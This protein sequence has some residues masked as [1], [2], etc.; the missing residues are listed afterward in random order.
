MSKGVASRTSRERG[1]RRGVSRFTSSER[2]GRVLGELVLGLALV[3]GGAVAMSAWFQRATTPTDVVVLGRDLQ[4]GHI[5]TSQDL[6]TAVVRGA[7]GLRVMKSD[8]PSLPEILGRRLMVDVAAGTPV[9]PGLLAPVEPLGIDEALVALAVRD[10]DFPT[11]LSASDRVEVVTLSLGSGLG[12]DDE[13]S[14]IRA[15]VIDVTPR[16]E[17]DAE[18]VVTLRAPR[19]LTSRLV[20]ADRVRL[21]VVAS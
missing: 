13:I 12:I 6:D 8:D 18:T 5:V 21:A 15:E 9:D 1:P 17:L 3:V 20:V 2:G 16:G 4:R 14:T 19:D 10:G 7:E 11:R